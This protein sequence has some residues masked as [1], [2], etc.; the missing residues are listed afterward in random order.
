MLEYLYR[1]IDLLFCFFVYIFEIQGE[2]KMKRTVLK[3]SSLLLVFL[4]VFISITSVLLVANANGPDE[5]PMEKPENFIRELAGNLNY[6]GDFSGGFS[7]STKKTFPTFNMKKYDFLEFDLYF[8]TDGYSGIRFYFLDDTYKNQNAGRGFV[9]ISADVGNWTHIKVK[10]TNF[11]CGYEMNGKVERTSG[12]MFEHL[13]G[14]GKSTDHIVVANMCLTAN[15]VVS[16]DTMPDRLL[17]NIGVDVDLTAMDNLGEDAGIVNIKETDFTY[18]DFVE[19]DYYIES[20]ENNDSSAISVYDTEGKKSAYSFDAV[21]NGWNHIKF[22]YKEFKGD[23]DL[24]KIVKYGCDKYVSGNVYHFANLCIT[25]VAIPKNL[26]ENIAVNLSTVLDYTGTKFVETITPFGKTVDFSEYDFFE[27]DFYVEAEGEYDKPNFF[28]YDSGYK[29]TGS[30]VANNRRQN[31]LTDFDIKNKEWNHIKLSVY[32]LM[33]GTGKGDLS[34]AAGIYLTNLSANT[35]YFIANICMTNVVAPQKKNV[36]TETKEISNIIKYRGSD[37]SN[38]QAF[39]SEDKSSYDAS[40]NEYV[41]F[42]FYVVSESKNETVNFG[43]TDSTYNGTN[44]VNKISKSVETNKWS[45]ILVKIS[46]LGGNAD[47]T[48]ATSFAVVSPQDRLKYFVYNISITDVLA[49]EMKN[50]FKLKKELGIEWDYTGKEPYATMKRFDTVN[51]KEYGYV[52]YDICVLSN[53]SNRLLRMFFIDKTFNNGNAGRGFYDFRVNTCG[54]QHIVI[55]CSAFD[56]GFDMNGDCTNVKGFFFDNLAAGERLVV[57]NVSLTVLEKPEP[58]TKY[59]LMKNTGVEINYVGNDPY[60][61]IVK[62]E[63]TDIMKYDFTEFDMYVYGDDTSIR[64]FFFDST[65]NR[66]GTGCGFYD[67]SLKTGE[68]KHIVISNAAFDTG[69]GMNG[70]K[71]DV[72]GYMIDNLSA[73]NQYIISNLCYTDVDVPELNPKYE[74]KKNLENLNW[75]FSGVSE[76]YK[77]KL[78]IETLDAT[79]YHYLEFDAYVDSADSS[80]FLRMF[81]Y[82]NSYKGENGGRGFKDFRITSNK[83]NHFI[84]ELKSFDTGYEM[85]GNLSAL[86]GFMLDSLNKNNTYFIYNMCLTSRKQSVPY[87]EG[88][89]AVEP[90]KNARY[91]SCCETPID[92][93]GSWNSDATYFTENYKTEG[94]KSI[95]LKVDNQPENVNN[96]KFGLEN[97]ADFSKTEK[98]CFDLMIDDIK[99]AKKTTVKF[100]LSSSKRGTSNNHIYYVDINKMKEGWNSLEIPVSSLK[101]DADLSSISCIMLAISSEFE[102]DDFY[103][104][105]LDNLRAVKSFDIQSEAENKDKPIGIDIDEPDIDFGDDDLNE[106]EPVT[107]F[108]DNF[109][110]DDLSFEDDSQNEIEQVQTNENIAPTKKIIRRFKKNGNSGMS[111]DLIVLIITAGACVLAICVLLILIILSKRKLDKLMKKQS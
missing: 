58:K 75:C 97:A 103:V 11:N 71:N 60:A 88:N 72:C 15:H 61:S 85:N 96:F 69:Y 70:N 43:L 52:E 41:E 90:D 76:P 7:L 83:W 49:P 95:A 35:R 12:V 101:G 82:D 17:T 10:T 3:I 37:C 54:W 111:I 9:D 93:L 62:T 29:G 87:D 56:I 63:R 79:K 66:K 68:W 45:H 46:E 78:P 26:P 73:G 47:I 80:V 8:D 102:P 55:P 28:V 44:G 40:K 1:K 39:L 6:T 67:L 64:L 105:C 74:I 34:K 86:S 77:T 33:N 30:P 92:A 42:D 57:K 20:K 50:D 59:K 5:P 22:P 107:D 4:I 98:I 108:E 48:K 99:L 81:F 84:F 65:F 18:G 91:I 106:N 32:T 110:Y 27:F 36:F 24:T 31:K 100:V 23:A 16:P 19:F 51:L 94:K 2:Q 109:A 13:G 38:A 104:L 21:S 89:R 14:T 53:D 25:G